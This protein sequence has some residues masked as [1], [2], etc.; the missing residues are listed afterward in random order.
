MR[1][2]RAPAVVMQTNKKQAA[3]PDARQMSAALAA[4]SGD[5]F[6][7]VADAPLMGTHINGRGIKPAPYKGCAPGIYTAP[8]W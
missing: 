8:E 5:A 1:V 6:V 2:W 4:T 7:L 3:S